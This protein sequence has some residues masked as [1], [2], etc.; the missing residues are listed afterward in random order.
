RSL[1]SKSDGT[2]VSTTSSGFRRIAGGMK[3]FEEP[4]AITGNL[5]IPVYDPQGT[6]IAPQNPCLPRVVGETDRQLYGLPFGVYLKLDGT[7]DNGVG[8]METYSGLKTTTDNCP[9]G[10]TECNANPIGTGIRGVALVPKTNTSSSCSGKTISAPIKGVGEWG[11]TAII[12]PT[13]WY[14]K[15]VK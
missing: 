4:L 14:E 8:G 2:E 10:A 6:G 1:S 11:C 7:V 15:W 13:R 5:V 3:A 12:N 9:D